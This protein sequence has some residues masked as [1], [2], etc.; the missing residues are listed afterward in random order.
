MQEKI[1]LIYRESCPNCGNIISSE[2]LL[3][4][5]P[6]NNCLKEEVDREN[7]CEKLEEG[8]LKEVCNIKKK[9]NDFKTIFLNSVKSNPWSLQETWALRYFMNTSFALI[10]P[11]G[12]GKTTFGLVLS[13]YI[14][15]NENGKVYLIFPTNLLVNQAKEKLISFGVK[16]D[17]IVAYSSK[18]FK[19]KKAQDLA[20][21]RIKE[22]DF[23]VLI[24]TTNF[25][26]KNFTIFPRGVFS[27][28]FIDDVDSIL[29]KAKHIDKIIY[30]LGLN[31]DDVK[32]TEE[33]VNLKKLLINKKIEENEE[34]LKKLSDLKSEIENIKEKR[35]GVLIVSSATSNPKS[36][37]IL[38][39][40][41]LFDFEIGRTSVSLRNIAE[42][43]ENSLQKDLYSLSL[44]RIKELG[45]GGLI[46]LPGD[47]TKE[48]IKEYVDFL[49]KNGVKAISYEEIEKKLASFKRGKIKV[50]VGFSS[51]K[52]PIARGLDLPESVRY[53][54]FVGVPKIKINLRLDNF[55]GIYYL[56]LSLLPVLTKRGILSREENLKIY[57]YLKYIENFLYFEEDKIPKTKLNKIE[58][59]VE[60]IKDIFLNEENI[61]KIEES[62]DAR[63]KKEDNLISIYI[64][65]VVGYIQA[66]GRTSRL[67]LGG[68]T[69]GL[70]YLIVDDEIL[71][72][73]LR[74]K[75]SWI[76]DE[77]EFR[78][79][80]EVDL[81]EIIKEIDLD[82]IKIKKAKIERGEIEKIDFKTTLIVVESP[83]KARTIANFFG[84][85]LKRKIGEI[86]VYEI[87]IENKFLIIVAT[88]G[89][90]FDLNK[91][92]GFFGVKKE[93]DEF[94]PVFEPID[95]SRKEIIKSLRKLAV[96]VNDIYLATDPDTEGEKISYDIYLSLKPINLNAKRIEFHEVT[97]KAFL[98]AIENFR[99]I[100]IELVKSQLL[101]RVSDRW[102]GFTVS[103]YI[104]KRLESLNLSA[105]RVQTPV[106]E[107]IVTR[108]FESKNKLFVVVIETD[109]EK[110]EFEF[111]DKSFG[112]WFFVNIK[113]IKIVK[114]K[115][116]IE[117]TFLKP[118]TTDTLL[119][120][121]TK[122][123]KFS[124][125]KIMELAQ[126]LFELGLITYHRTD[127]IR[128]SDTGVKI[129]YEYIKENFGEKFIKIRKFEDEKGA[130]EC[131]RP[132]KSIDTE[133]LKSFLFY[134][135]I[136]GITD[137]HLKL[138]DLI[139][140]QFIASQMREVKIKKGVINYIPICDSKELK[141]LGKRERKVIEIVENGYNMIMPIKIEK[142][143][144]GEFKIKNK[145][146][147]Y[148]SKVPLYTF[149]SIIQEMKEKGIG[150]PSTYAITID[151]LLKR[152]YIV[153]KGGVL[154]PT[155]LGIDVIN[156]IKK[157]KDIY[158]FVRESYTKEL[159]E[160]MDKIEK[161]ES[162]Y[163]LELK[164][165]FENLRANS[166][167]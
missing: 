96:E 44:E 13:K 14:V 1:P 83:N 82:R 161:R 69:K 114:E 142:L 115:D 72:D 121:G 116:E 90:V 47:K 64:P 67:Y 73:S 109:D 162:D 138:Y 141:D 26:Y 52:N 30:L 54:L 144:E 122:F 24:T 60:E 50:V 76:S 110:V 84:K 61:K 152:G 148:K 85:P 20:K 39:F 164:K 159:E 19:T 80:E 65:D 48:D 49:N 71:F 34:T 157:R 31:E 107:W 117:T 25:L 113:G 92:E 89:H 74:K 8:F 91:E 42:I 56:L 93:E 45:N 166:L 163:K 131:I 103:Q 153:E 120:N 21:K 12:I 101:R 86:E 23:K 154:L 2:R 32:K 88:K 111:D 3:K 66:S 105:G 155:Q 57:K 145:S 150:R 77:F 46:F 36:S 143:Y 35:K 68:L 87:S 9:L 37:K 136:Q 94:I 151:K 11:T 102:I 63:I 51:F 125:Q 165:L 147:Y 97:K 29:K 62:K 134:S 160:T 127:S 59:I 100:D 5:L 17:Y 137:E 106:L 129:A 98:S 126:D 128:V 118:F 156:L 75:L 58:K 140:K 146:Y 123:L 6:C 139:F 40:R 79:R 27:L 43:Y 33:L 78:K 104:Q 41:E 28:L 53:A 81:D 108:F 95:E 133:E 158:F 38:L 16:E 10:A 119:S 112:Q 18:F 15:E 70:S 132:T 55:K 135:N 149:S 4:G 22:S 167:L 130:H 7:L 99:D 124:P